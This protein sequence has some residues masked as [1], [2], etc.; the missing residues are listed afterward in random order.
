MKLNKLTILAMALVTLAGSGCS[1]DDYDY[2]KGDAY[3]TL[4]FSLNANNQLN[5]SIISRADDTTITISDALG[6]TFDA[7]SFLTANQGSFNLSI[8]DSNEFE[9]YNGTLGEWDSA[10]EL[11]F[12]T[13][14]VE[15]IYVGAIGFYGEGEEGQPEFESEDVSFTIAE[16]TEYA[17]EIPVA[18]ANSIL[19]VRY[20]DMFKN[21]F[22]DCTTNVTATGSDTPVTYDYNETRGAFFP[23][24]KVSIK[25]TL[26]RSQAQGVNTATIEKT[27]EQTLAAKTCHT[28]TY[29]V[30]NVGGVNKLTISLDDTN[31]V[32]VAIDEIDL[33]E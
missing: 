5:T 33:N 10:T 29:D 32:D 1:S 11:S 22:S 27:I 15:A 13:Y 24:T 2:G 17:V 21:Y 3:G 12:G 14:N 8:E 25:Y 18:L 20:T 28:L 4:S 26:T 9:K 23:A 30:T 7:T 16:A 6:T 19:R 31:I